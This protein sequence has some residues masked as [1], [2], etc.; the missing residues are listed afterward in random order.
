MIAKIKIFLKNIK[1]VCYSLLLNKVFYKKIMKK[2]YKLTDILTSPFF[3]S[4]LIYFIF[5]MIF[6]ENM[7]SLEGSKAWLYLFFLLFTLG[8]WPYLIV[9]YSLYKLDVQKTGWKIFTAVL[10]WSI[11]LAALSFFSLISA[12]YAY[13]VKAAVLLMDLYL[14]VYL[15]FLIIAFTLGLDK[16]M[17]SLGLV[18][19]IVFV[20]NLPWPTDLLIVTVVLLLSAAYSYFARLYNL[21]SVSNLLLS[22]LIGALVNVLDKLIPKLIY[23]FY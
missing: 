6:M 10:V 14:Y 7:I 8:Y 20:F 4:G 5:S 22:F 11:F 19:G 17:F 12:G 23:L 2:L 16:N 13:Q 21:A 18:V 15:I 3:M 9:D 1:I